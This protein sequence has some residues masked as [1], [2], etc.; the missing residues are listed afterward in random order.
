MAT[1]VRLRAAMAGISKSRRTA[2]LAAAVKP[3]LE[4]ASIRKDFGLTRDKFARLLG[5]SV[6]SIAAWESGTVVKSAAAQRIR[7]MNRLASALARI[8]KP[9]L[10]PVWLETPNEGFDGLKPI[11]VVERGELD[12]LWR[13]IYMVES[14]TPS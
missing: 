11:E 1:K 6:R 10:I 14:G 8:M 2:S 4:V 13:M 9:S 12:R 5:Y 7:E 3:G